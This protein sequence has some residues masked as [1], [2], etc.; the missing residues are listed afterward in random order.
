VTGD[1]YDFA[2][3]GIVV[4]VGHWE[5]ECCGPSYERDAVVELTCFVI[6]PGVEDVGAGGVQYL[7]T[8]HDG[9]TSKHKATSIRGRVSDLAIV[10]LDGS[11]EPIER[12]PG[13]RAIRGFDDDDDGH[14]E[15]PWTSVAVINDSNRFLVTIAS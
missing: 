9:L 6:P 2:A 8:H 7:E 13:G 15:R 11:V 4:E 10:H 1:G 14:L 5:H 12:L 3:A